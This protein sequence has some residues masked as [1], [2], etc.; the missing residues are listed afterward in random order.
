M[1]KYSNFILVFLVALATSCSAPK[2]VAYLW[3]SDDVDLSQSEYLY[4]A[5]IMPKDVLTITVNTVNPEAAAPFNLTVPTSFNNQSRST[6]S[7]PILQTYLVDNEGTIDYPVLGRIKVGGLTKR[8]CETMIHDK[9]K[10]YLNANEKPVV[11]VRMS[12]YS[13][14]VLGEVARP[15]SYQVSREKINILEALAQAGDLTIY[16]V[17]EN[18]KLIREDSKGKKQIYHINLNDANLLTSPYYYL[19]QNDI[20]Y[21]EP[22]KV[23]A[24]NSTVGQTTTLW[25]S[26]T[27]ILISMASLLYNILK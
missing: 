10:P 9:I 21:V 26:A 20:V 12:S 17:R 19:Q 15:G 22:N 27:S 3:N 14:S 16:G 13:I 11:T 25:F 2:N 5:K 18:V 6:Y 1:K 8:E 4:D 7:Q 23:K 24:R